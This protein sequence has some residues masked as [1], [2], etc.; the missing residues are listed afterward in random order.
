MKIL[1]IEDEKYLGD[2]LQNLLEKE[3]YKTHICY[4]GES[5]LDEALT[6]VYDLILLDIMLPRVDGLQILQLIR[7]EKIMTKVLLLTARNQ[8]S[9]RV[10]GLDLGADDYLS[11]PFAFVE[12]MARVKALLRRQGELTNDEL[13]YGDLH[14]DYRAFQLYKD[15]EAIQ[16]TLKECE[17]LQV[18]MQRKQMISSKDMLI[19]KLWGYDSDAE[20]NN[21]EVYISFLRKKLKYLNSQ[22][23]IKTTR[24]VGYSLEANCV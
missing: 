21:V 3:N 15:D 6:D 22:C 14:L 10:K 7:E 20:D 5:G 19:E 12:L 24:G 18:L 1:I 13:V 11:K 4:D 2:A 8:V 23:H 16:L 9:D 17:I